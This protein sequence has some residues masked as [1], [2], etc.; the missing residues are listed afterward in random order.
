MGSLDRLHPRLQHAIVHDLGWR[1]L[2][3]VRVL[4]ELDAR[5]RTPLPLFE[6]GR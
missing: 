3:P 4:I 1:S 5:L 6:V 2:R